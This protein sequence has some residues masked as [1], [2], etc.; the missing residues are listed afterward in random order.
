M[1][2][3]SNMDFAYAPPPI[4]NSL[5]SARQSKC[6]CKPMQDS[7]S[8]P[9]LYSKTLG[10][11]PSLN[12]TAL[13]GIIALAPYFILPFSPFITFVI[14]LLLMI[15]FAPVLSKENRVF[16][17]IAVILSGAFLN[18]DIQLFY[19]FGTYYGVF[20]HIA[21]NDLKSALSFFGSG[22]ELALPTVYWV[23]LKIFGKLAPQHFVML[24]IICTA[25][26]FY[27]W[28]EVYGIKKVAKHQ[29]A[30]CVAITLIY[31]DFWMS[32][33]GVR[34]IVASIFMLYALSA[35]SA[36]ASWVFFIISVLFHTSSLIFYPI[37]WLLYN[38]PRIGLALC[39][40]ISI[41]FIFFNDIINYLYN[42]QTD[43]KL[44]L[45]F[46]YKVYF[47]MGNPIDNDIGIRSI[48]LTILPS[49]LSLIYLN[50]GFK[51]WKAVIIGLSFLCFSA[52]FAHAHLSYRLGMISLFIMAGYFLFLSLRKQPFILILFS[53]F[54]LL[55]LASIKSVFSI[56][57]SAK[58][59]A[60]YDIIGS[61]FYYL[62]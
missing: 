55:I 38:R 62:Y 35:R 49:I 18:G 11:T 8:T 40:I 45:A 32:G 37:I 23:W 58:I 36:N 27:I 53:L 7:R 2:F 41:F 46:K 16:L 29:K 10:A 6:D 56:L 33:F 19:D 24:Q 21:N 30:L 5:D 48:I 4:D 15:V 59:W 1:K 52:L 43:I 60:N 12:S 26:L 34:Q 14:S 22:I 9:P 3:K 39:I 50:K 31:F 20:S 44:L 17:S 51:Q 61:F 13:N 54:S 25:S 47:Y 42:M 57:S 28:L